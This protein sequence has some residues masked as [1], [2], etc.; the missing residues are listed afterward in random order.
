MKI[1]FPQT[2]T[3]KIFSRML[4]TNTT[5]GSNSPKIEKKMIPIT[6][7]DKRNKKTNLNKDFF[8]II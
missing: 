6:T 8:F 5:E 4:Q 2:S 1:V 3:P 7:E